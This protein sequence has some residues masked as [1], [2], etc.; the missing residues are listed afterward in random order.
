MKTMLAALIALAALAG[1]A[2]SVAA[3]RRPDF[4]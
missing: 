1:V 3:G 4:L 2:G